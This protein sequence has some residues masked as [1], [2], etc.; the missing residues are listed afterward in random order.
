MNWIL[1]ES[2]SKLKFVIKVY[3][4]RTYIAARAH[5]HMHVHCN[6][7]SRDLFL[8][9]KFK[10]Y[11]AMAARVPMAEVLQLD[12]T[13]LSLVTTQTSEKMVRICTESLLRVIANNTSSSVV[14]R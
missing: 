4:L 9:F 14:H 12:D 8:K 10:T 7:K 3:E 1:S 6:V 2:G 13:N 11:P 5:V